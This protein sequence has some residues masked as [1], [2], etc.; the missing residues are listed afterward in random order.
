[1]HICMN[2]PLIMF[3]KWHLVM[4]RQNSCS[5]LGMPL[6]QLCRLAVDIVSTNTSG[7]V[8][9]GVPVVVD[10][11]MCRSDEDNFEKGGTFL[12]LAFRLESN[13]RVTGR[14]CRFMR[15]T[16]TLNLLGSTFPCRVS[17]EVDRRIVLQTTCAAISHGALHISWER[18]GYFS[19]CEQWSLIIAHVILDG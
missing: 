8:A 5:R 13:V 14:V 9:V 11:L 19:L 2:S 4:S 7:A 10:E 16:G 18:A 6:Q 1:M 3:T 15:V 17:L 12:C